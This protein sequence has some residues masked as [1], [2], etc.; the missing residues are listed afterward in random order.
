LSWAWWTGIFTLFCAFIIVVHG[1]SRG[2]LP[3]SP[4]HLHLQV[5]PAASGKCGAS[6]TPEEVS[7]GEEV[8]AVSHLVNVQ[9][10]R[11]AVYLHGLGQ[12]LA[13]QA[14]CGAQR[15]GAQA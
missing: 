15:D 14:E 11:L 2:D 1:V 10:F 3:M 13:G 8:V 12:S 6:D 9:P 5:A 7:Q 4:M